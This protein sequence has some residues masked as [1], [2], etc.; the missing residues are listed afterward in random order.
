MHAQREREREI[1]EVCFLVVAV[2]GQVLV[3]S[4]VEER[5]LVCVDAAPHLSTVTNLFLN[6]Q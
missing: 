3:N 2:A 4:G 6:S 1:N 5:G